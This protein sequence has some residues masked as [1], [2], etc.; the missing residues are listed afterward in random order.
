MGPRQAAGSKAACEGGFPGIYDLSASVEEWTDECTGSDCLS[1]GSNYT[2]SDGFECA[3]A[4]NQLQ[5]RTLAESWRGFRC[6][7]P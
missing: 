4:A 3:T 5:P 2:N 1:R 6:C 7:S